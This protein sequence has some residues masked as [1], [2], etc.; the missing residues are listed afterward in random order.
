[1]NKRFN[2]RKLIWYNT[3]KLLGYEGYL[4][5]GIKTGIT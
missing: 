3:N 4:I 1:M 2:N 5:N